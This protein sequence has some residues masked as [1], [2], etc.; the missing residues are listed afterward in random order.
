MWTFTLYILYK[1]MNKNPKRSEIS[2]EELARFIFC[3]LWQ[4]NHLVFH[5]GRDDLRY[6]LQYI[7]RLG[8]IGLED[9]QDFS[10][11]RIKVDNKEKLKRIANIVE[12]TSSLTGVK[13]FDDYVKRID[14]A[15]LCEVAP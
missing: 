5:D 2:F 12:Q 3:Q 14:E 8:M 1:F 4:K 15:L 11:I 6:D 10:K 7:N 9:N 13:L